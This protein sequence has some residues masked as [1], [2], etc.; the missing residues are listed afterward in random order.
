MQIINYFQTNYQIYYQNFI[1]IELLDKRNQ[2]IIEKYKYLLLLILIMKN[3][4][5]KSS[6]YLYIYLSNF[7]T[8]YY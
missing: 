7:V 8:F 4:I 5:Y 1:F 6:Q 3:I 2:N